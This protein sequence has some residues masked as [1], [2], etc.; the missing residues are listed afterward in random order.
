MEPTMQ[1]QKSL[2][3]LIIALI[4]STAAL[5]ISRADWLYNGSDTI[6]ETGDGVVTPWTIY[7]SA[8]GEGYLQLKQK[9]GSTSYGQIGTN[10]DGTTSAIDL[11]APIRLAS[12]PSITYKINKMGDSFFWGKPVVSVILPDALTT[13]PKTA[14]RDCTSITNLV[15]GRNVSS[16]GYMAF[17]NAQN[18]KSDLVFNAKKITSI[19]SDAFN[20]CYNVPNIIFNGEITQSTIGGNTFRACRSL[21]T[22]KLSGLINPSG[23]NY[24][25]DYCFMGT[26]IKE[27]WM[28]KYPEWGTRVWEARDGYGVS[29]YN[30]S[31]QIYINPKNAGWMNAYKPWA[32]L[33]DTVKAK[34]TRT[35]TK[36]L[37]L[38]TKA[39][40]NQWVL[41]WPSGLL[42]TV[43]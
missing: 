11:N 24:F 42:L 15:I 29:K 6:T 30:Y 40:A 31:T 5:H 33:T 21:K 32:E 41:A 9:A 4:V 35:D 37:G 14:F 18:L 25:G 2:I 26:E 8:N 1:T 16:I 17:Y 23:I 34:W 10:A 19:A 7:V 43:R 27:L 36:P 39:P 22:L 3:T 12:D 28:P 13:I 20:G 38:T